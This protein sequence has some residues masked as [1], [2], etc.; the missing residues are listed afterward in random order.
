MSACSL[1]AGQSHLQVYLAD[2]L[3]ALTPHQEI[4]RAC[5]NSSSPD[6]NSPTMGKLGRIVLHSGAEFSPLYQ[7]HGVQ[8]LPPLLFSTAEKECSAGHVALQIGAL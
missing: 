2:H 3:S 1:N 4:G 6:I 7:R 5:R 8:E